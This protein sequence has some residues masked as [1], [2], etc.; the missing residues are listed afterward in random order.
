MQL[1]TTSMWKSMLLLAALCASIHAGAEIKIQHDVSYLGADR[2]EKADIYTP[3]GAHSDPMPAVLIIHGGGWKTGD[4]ADHRGISI[5][6]DLAGQGY[7]VMAI[8]YLLAPSDD[9]AKSSEA[10]GAFPQNVYDCKTAIRYMR[11]H[12]KELGIDPNRIGIL[13]ESAGGHLV[14]LLG[15]TG[16][17]GD[18]NKNGLYLDQSNDVA[19][20]ID[21][22]GIP[23][24][25]DPTIHHIRGPFKGAT[26]AETTANVERANP[27]RY[28]DKSMPPTLILHGTADTT[29]PIEQSISLDAKLTQLGVPHEFVKVPEGH[30]SFDLHPQQM[31]VRPVVF[32]FL[33][34]YLQP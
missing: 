2:A 7:V 8:N 3:S 20:V 16:H 18:M 30:H 14:V 26:D 25:E 11:A 10:K 24:L 4:K 33:K 28:I 34:K 23:N 31:D 27:W 21:M 29:V 22:Y 19:C 1:K 12:A 17:S 32:A 6:T 9:A 5:S 13:G 15:A